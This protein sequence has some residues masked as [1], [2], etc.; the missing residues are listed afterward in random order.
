MIFPSENKRKFGPVFSLG[1]LFGY[2][3]PWKKKKKLFIV[4]SKMLSVYMLLDVQ[5][6]NIQNLHSADEESRLQKDVM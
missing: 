4:R 6:W 3:L 5:L 1:L 2:C